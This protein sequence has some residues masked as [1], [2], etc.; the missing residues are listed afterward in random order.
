MG[1]GRVGGPWHRP[2]LHAGTIRSLERPAAYA[3]PVPTPRGVRP[4]AAGPNPKREAWFLGVTHVASR[5]GCR[6]DRPGPI[7]DP[8]SPPRLRSAYGPHTIAA[9]ARPSRDRPRRVRDA[10]APAPT[11]LGCDRRRGCRTVPWGR[12]VPNGRRISTMSVTLD[13]PPAKVWP[14]LIQMGPTVQAGTAGTGSTTVDARAP[15]ACIRNGSRW[16]S[17]IAVLPHLTAGTG[18]RSLH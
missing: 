14:W 11:A 2:S 13:A 9:L 4:G 17:E 8:D 18:S 10:R 7:P 15:I 12:S 16:P 3:G 6:R 1:N 5:V